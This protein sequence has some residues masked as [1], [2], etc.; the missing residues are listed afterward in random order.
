M[1]SATEGSVLH[2]FTLFSSTPNGYP[3]NV[4]N[5][6]NKNWNQ[7]SYLSIEFITA[8][9][10]NLVLHVEVENQTLHDSPLPFMVYPGTLKNEQDSIF[11]IKIHIVKQFHLLQ[12]LWMC[13]VVWLK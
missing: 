5:I 2:N 7:Q 9:A 11:I 3:T 6:T 1:S 12:G 10:G 8:K 4:L 13:I